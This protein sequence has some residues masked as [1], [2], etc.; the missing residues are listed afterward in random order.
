MIGMSFAEFGVLLILGIIS[1]L[2]LHY[3]VR[4][5]V[6]AGGDGFVAKWI[7][8]WVGGW[9]GSPVL[10]HWFTGINVGHVYIIPALIG[11]F[12]GSFMLTAMWKAAMLTTRVPNTYTTQPVMKSHDVTKAA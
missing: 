11:A 12:V 10:G 5:R 7:M 9:L 2:V 1:S 8:G 3:A 6:L 4:Y